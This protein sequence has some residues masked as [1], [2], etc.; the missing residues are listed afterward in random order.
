MQD[1]QMP[2][3]DIEALYAEE[4]AVEGELFAT[5][6]EWARNVVGLLAYEADLLEEMPYEAMGGRVWCA[7]LRT[8]IAQATAILNFRHPE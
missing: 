4:V 8:I 3:E 2:E 7:K 1:N 5:D 6:A